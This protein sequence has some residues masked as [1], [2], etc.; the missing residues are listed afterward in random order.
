MHE[1]VT[2][3]VNKDINHAK[4]K[5]IRQYE[6]YSLGTNEHIRQKKNNIT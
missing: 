5:F 3:G 6:N 2:C 1:I 4:Q